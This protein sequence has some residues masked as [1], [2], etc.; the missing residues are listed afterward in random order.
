VDQGWHSVRA[1]DPVK[2]A[3]TG[4]PPRVA[5]HNNPKVRS[6]FYQVAV[7]AVVLACA[8]A[9][10]VNASANLRA[11][12]FASGFGFLG[13]TAGFGIN[14]TLIDYSETDTYGRVFVVGLLNTLVVAIIGCVLATVL[15]FIIGIARLSPNWLIARLGGVYVETIRNLPLLFQIL[16]WYLAVLGTMPSPRSSIGLGLQPILSAIGDGIAALG[17]PGADAFRS[18]AASIG[19]P[20]VYLNNRGVILPRPLLGDGFEWVAIAFGLAVVLAVVLRIW[21]RQ[22]LDATGK[23]FPAGWAAFALIVGLPGVVLL[24]LG[25]PIGF[26]HPQLR[27]FNFVGGVR[28]IPELVALLFALVTYTAAFIAEV[29]RAGI[30]AVPRGQSEASQALGLKRGLALRLIIVPQALRVIIPPLTNQYLN[31]TKNSSLAVAIGYPDLF[32]VFAG[33]TLNQ[34]HQAIEIIAITM[35]VYLAISLITSILM[36]WYNARSNRRF[37]R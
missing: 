33:T 11:Q 31:L 36:N 20:D 18:L 14:Q 28:V 4:G 32:A 12:G 10:A 21:A 17:L 26:E 22:R 24:A 37:E 2:E 9:F 3:L 27:G 16:F 15:G 29:V 8:Y 34:T 23:T 25:V 6:A 5:V 7:L 1:A 13:N 35:A 30:Q 19:P